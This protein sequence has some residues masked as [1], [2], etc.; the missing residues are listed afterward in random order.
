M[1]G[2][3]LIKKRQLK[4]KD[5]E[6]SSLKEQMQQWKSFY[7]QSAQEAATLRREAQRLTEYANQMTAKHAEVVK[8][9]RK[10][11]GLLESL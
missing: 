11:E 3:T 7:E 4:Q 10:I 9:Y 8:A 1:F 6:I 5:H 2:Y